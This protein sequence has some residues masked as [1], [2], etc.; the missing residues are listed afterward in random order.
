MVGTRE[1][2]VVDAQG[3]SCPQPVILARQAI[4]SIS[5]GLIEVLVDTGTQRD[6]ILRLASM[7]SCSARV[8]NTSEGAYCITLEK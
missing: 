1:I 5:S 7:E 3:L 4:K 2:L 6:N 8:D